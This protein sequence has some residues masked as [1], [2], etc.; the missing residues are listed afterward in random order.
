MIFSYAGACK[1]GQDPTK[2]GI[3]PAALFLIMYVWNTSR[4]LKLF[5]SLFSSALVYFIVGAIY[6]GL[7]KHRSGIN[8]IPNAKFWIGLPLYAIVS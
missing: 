3:S 4:I 6:N 5:F 2:N 7:V 1:N 8:L